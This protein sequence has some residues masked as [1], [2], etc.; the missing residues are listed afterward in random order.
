M[1]HILMSLIFLAG[2]FAY[3]ETT[4]RIPVFVTGVPQKKS[5]KQQKQDA[6]TPVAWLNKKIEK[7]GGEKIQSFIEI[8]EQKDAE[9]FDVV[10]KKISEAAKLLGPEYEYLELQ[11]ES[12]PNQNRRGDFETCYT[13]RGDGV[14][15]V[16]SAIA[17]YYYTEQ[18]N[19]WGWKY[20][21][22]TKIVD[23][24]I[25]VSWLNARSKVWKNWKGSDDSVLVMTAMGDGGDDVESN[26]IP[27][28]DD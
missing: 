17:G 25:N 18:L 13:G 26:I 4:L 10:A 22:T 9:Q 5:P 19:L 15:N 21:D 16:V 23:P 14:A 27:R 24:Q 12:I 2:A 8:S 7:A 20:K 3:A 6:P 28:C 11:S 1:K